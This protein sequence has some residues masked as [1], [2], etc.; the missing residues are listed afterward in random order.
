MKIASV[1]FEAFHKII[2]K[3]DS[4]FLVGHSLGAQLGGM[5]GRKLTEQSS[6]GTKLKR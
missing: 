4:V 5:I 1:L 3:I 2:L 6:N